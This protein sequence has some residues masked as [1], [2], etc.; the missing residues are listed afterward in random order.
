MIDVVCSTHG[1]SNIHV[2]LQTFNLKRCTKENYLRDLQFCHDAMIP[3]TRAQRCPNRDSIGRQ[4]HV[5]QKRWDLYVLHASYLKLCY[6]LMAACAFDRTRCRVRFKWFHN[7]DKFFR[8]ELGHVKSHKVRVRYSPGGT[9]NINKRMILKRNLIFEMTIG[10]EW[11][12]T[13]SIGGIL[14]RRNRWNWSR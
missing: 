10:S 7:R 4:S 9:I 1:E 2:K 11:F 8:A 5:E 14:Y 3:R 13:G 6:G 12:N